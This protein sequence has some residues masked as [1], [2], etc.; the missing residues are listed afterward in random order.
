MS[1][2]SGRGRARVPGVPP[3][4]PAPRDEERG[5]GSWTGWDEDEDDK[6]DDD[7]D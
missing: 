7:D 5:A 3:A 6:E 2:D 4:D 1:R